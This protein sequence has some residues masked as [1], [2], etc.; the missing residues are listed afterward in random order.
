MT[1]NI[2]DS[3][4]SVI[5]KHYSAPTSAS[6]ELLLLADLGKTLQASGFWPPA[7]DQRPLARIVEEMAPEIVLVR[8]P[9]VPAY[10]AVVPAG[11]QQLAAEAIARRHETDLLSKLPRPILVAF[12][13]KAD[14]QAVHVRITAPYRYYIGEATETDLVEVEERFRLPGLYVHDPRALSAADAVALVK[15]IEGWAKQHN[16]PIETLYAENRTKSPTPAPGVRQ[17]NRGTNALE[18]LY[19]AQPPGLAEKM[20][21]PFDIAVSL[22][23]L[24]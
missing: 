10:I 2:T 13:L 12:C 22:S 9:D 6:T 19:A 21:M 20:V 17:A 7:D 4:R 1:Q 16:I 18:R 3:I 15:K 14:N 5:E 24:P 23:R 8:D 11:K